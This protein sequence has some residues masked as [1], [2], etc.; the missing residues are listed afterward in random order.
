MPEQKKFDGHSPAPYE[1]AVAETVGRLGAPMLTNPN[2]EA[3]GIGYAGM[4]IRKAAP[5]PTAAAS[6]LVLVQGS[7]PKKMRHRKGVSFS[8]VETTGIGF[9]DINGP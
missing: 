4:G 7:R 9:A 5:P 6:H 3:T 8:L 1:A 2:V